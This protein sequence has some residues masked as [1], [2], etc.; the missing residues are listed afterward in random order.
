MSCTSGMV[1]CVLLWFSPVQSRVSPPKNKISSAFFAFSTASAN[2][3]CIISFVIA[4]VCKCDFNARLCL[5]CLQRCD[6][7]SGIT[8]GA[9]RITQVI[10]ARIRQ[11]TR[12][13]YMFL[14]RFRGDVLSSFFNRTADCAAATLRARSKGC[15]SLHQFPALPH[16]YGTD[17]QTV[18]MHI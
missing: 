4:S 10:L 5:Q 13:K 17:V 7:I 6:D 12:D 1:M 9:P 15:R 14:P 2:H 11:R 18:P 16:P 3:F 8:A